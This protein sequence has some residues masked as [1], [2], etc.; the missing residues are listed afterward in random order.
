M[1][2]DADNTSFLVTVDRDDRTMVGVYPDAHIHQGRGKIAAINAHMDKAGEWDIVLLASDDMLPQVHGY[3]NAIREAFE[4]HFKDTDGFLWINDGRQEKIC[5]ILCMGRK[6]YLRFGYLYYP[7]YRSFYCDNES[8][9][10]AQALGKVVKVP[11]LIRHEHPMW[12]GSHPQDG[13]YRKN[14]QWF[15]AD[16][17]TYKRRKAQGFPK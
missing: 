3:D 14:N 8:L 16:E 9:D 15:K 11:C 1:L 5:T 7:A 6:Y 2:A 17:R 12:G 4:T 10:V 13:L